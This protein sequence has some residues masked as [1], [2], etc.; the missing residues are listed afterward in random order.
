MKAEVISIGTEL[1]MG[2]VLN[3]NAQFL[4]RRLSAL[5]IAQYHQTTVGDNPERLKAAYQTALERSDVVI[6]SGGLGPTGDDITKAV[7]AQ[8]LQKPLVLNPCAQQSI[9]TYFKRLNRP[10]AKNNLAQ[11][12][13]TEDTTILYNPNGSAPGAIV[14]CDCFGDNK[15]VIHLP[16]PPS[17]LRPMFDQDVMPYLQA[18]SGQCIV[19]RYIRIFGMGESD[20]DMK[21]RDLMEQANPSLSPY[22]SLGEVQLRATALCQS[23]AEGIHMLEPVIEEIKARLGDVIY[24][25]C[26]DD[27]TSL[28]AQT[29]AEIKAKKLTISV[30]ESVTGGLLASQI[31]AISGASSVFKGGLLTYSNDMKVALAGVQA[32]TIE[33]YGAVSEQC[34]MEM[35]RGVRER[36]QSDIGIALTG[37]AGPNSDE[38]STPVGLVFVGIDSIRGTRSIMLHLSGNRERIRTLCALNALNILRI[39]TRNM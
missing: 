8:L 14:P 11:A 24:A 29:I 15:V 37:C 30:C 38:R 13:F 4:S 7:L 26:E 27:T 28:A 33:Q 18:R 5:G 25:I 21:L 32:K 2:Q 12:M 1:L 20:V 31:V 6:T 3:T 36:T 34:A 17:E 10:M 35:A 39:E 22:C 23:Q 16:G 19:S 9:E